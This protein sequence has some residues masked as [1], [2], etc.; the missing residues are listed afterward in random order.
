MGLFATT[1][2]RTESGT[3]NA[4]HTGVAYREKVRSGRR[5]RGANTDLCSKTEIVEILGIRDEI[6]EI[7]SR[8]LNDLKARQFFTQHLKHH[9]DSWEQG[10]LEGQ[11]KDISPSGSECRETSNVAFKSDVESL[12]KWLEDE[13]YAL[14]ASKCRVTKYFAICPMSS[15]LR[16]ALFAIF[17]ARTGSNHDRRVAS[18]TLSERAVDDLV[19][20]SRSTLEGN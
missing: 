8:L 16:A 2:P 17:Q 15:N 13:S 18:E 19:R 12:N 4:R 11:P 10:A 9:F 3:I 7:K 6:A 20:S 1:W 5:Y 14:I